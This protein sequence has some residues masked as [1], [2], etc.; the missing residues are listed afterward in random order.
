MYCKTSINVELTIIFQYLQDNFGGDN[1]DLYDDVISAPPATNPEGDD[2]NHQSNAS[3]T[4]DQPGN[5]AGA[6]VTV[7]N[8]PNA[9]GRRHQLYVGNLTWVSK[10]STNSS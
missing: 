10:Q 6:Q 9:S 4:D 7:V 8:T 1:V 2:A 3:G 5:F